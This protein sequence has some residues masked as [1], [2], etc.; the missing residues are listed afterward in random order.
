MLLGN[1]ESEHYLVSADAKIRWVLRTLDNQNKDYEIFTIPFLLA[2]DMVYGKIRNLKYR[3][4]PDY[5]VSDE[6]VKVTITGKILDMDYTRLLAQNP[7]LSLDDIVMLDKVQKN[8]PLTDDER[9][10]L[11]LKKLIEG[12]KP[13]FFISKDIAQNTEQKAEYS[14]TRHLKKKN[15]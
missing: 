7:N 1:E 9:K 8:K 2:V 11:K 12:R 14:K 4:L 3:Y 6:K 15:I 10:Y 13:Y 5:D